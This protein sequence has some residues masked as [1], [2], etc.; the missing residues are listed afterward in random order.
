MSILEDLELLDLTDDLPDGAE[1]DLDDILSEFSTPGLFAITEAES[2]PLP[3]IIEEDDST[4][5]FAAIAEP[6]EAVPVE[7][8]PV[9]EETVVI[10]VIT[11]ATEDF[12]SEEDEDM[13]VIGEAL[14]PRIP[15]RIT[16]TCSGIP[17]A[18]AI[19]SMSS[20]L[21]RMTTVSRFTPPQT[22]LH[23]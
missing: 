13:K 17:S 19:F 16:V 14:W 2:E 3:E 8:A 5:V 11:E 18:S 23:P 7:E 20:A 1:F 10:P 4:L 12:F 9:C 21:P 22:R 6:V 15:L